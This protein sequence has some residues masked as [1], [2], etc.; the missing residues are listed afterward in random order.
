MAD[1]QEIDCLYMDL[2]QLRY[3]LHAAKTQNLSHA[4][5]N[6]AISQSAL[7]RQIKILEEELGVALFIRQARGLQLTPAGETLISPAQA[8]LQDADELKQAVRST[9]AV[10]AGT[11]RIGTP[12]S[13]RS[14]I[15]LPFFVEFHRRYPDVLI[16][17]SQGTS[18]GMRDALAE[19]EIDIAITS[20][21]EALELFVIERL[22]D[23]QLCWVGQYAP[24]SS[25]A[26][27]V[28]AKRLIEHP[29]ILT[30]YPNSLR[31]IVDQKLRA[32]GLRV[33]PIAELDNAD[34]MIDMVNAGLGYTVLPR[35]GVCDAHRRKFVSAYPIRG[36]KIEW[37]AARSRERVQSV[38]SKRAVDILKSISEKFNSSTHSF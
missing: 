6:A 9:Q 2:R 1:I 25:N 30:R 22:F 35:S 34:M 3:F 10:P 15:M 24:P 27:F 11:L 7:S 18:K 28:S 5:G 4:S 20:S 8:L 36:L 19:G 13:L 29:L 38:A 12:S 14:Q 16:I 37:M 21:T 17:H 26:T 32:L 31:I 33:Q 23:E